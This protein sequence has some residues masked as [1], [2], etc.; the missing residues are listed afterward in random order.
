MDSSTT[1]QRIVRGIVA[2]ALAASAG[3][4]LVACQTTRIE[5]VPEP[6]VYEDPMVDQQRVQQAADRIRERYSGRPADRIDDAVAREA[7][8][9]EH[10]RERY[11]G[12]PADRIDEAMARKQQR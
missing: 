11:S 8:D 6:V 12:L 10:V 3:I 5:P 9:A 7:Q 4:G 1:S 2:A